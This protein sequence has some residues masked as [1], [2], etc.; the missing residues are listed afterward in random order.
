MTLR[1]S[2]VSHVLSLSKL[3]C[4]ERDLPKQGSIT[5]STFDCALMCVICPYKPPRLNLYCA[6]QKSE[7]QKPTRQ[8]CTLAKPWNGSMDYWEALRS[9]VG[10][11]THAALVR[12][13][14][15]RKPICMIDKKST[16]DWFIN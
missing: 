15:M 7:G 3:T 16:S 11:E 10:R 5:A 12:P 1:S 2:V 6:M 8:V 4:N 14:N 9:A 13:G